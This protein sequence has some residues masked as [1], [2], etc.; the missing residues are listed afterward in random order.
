MKRKD[1]ENDDNV[2]MRK[3]KI[4]KK[5]SDFRI[6]LN[7]KKVLQMQSKIWWLAYSRFMNSITLAFKKIKRGGR[8]N[9][10]KWYK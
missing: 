4:N 7:I 5:A 1:L 8:K 3:R 6:F 9:G 10:N 2:R